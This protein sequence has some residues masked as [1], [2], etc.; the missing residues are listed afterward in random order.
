MPSRSSTWLWRAPFLGLASVLMAACSQSSPPSSTTGTPPGP[1]PETAKPIS[2]GRSL[3]IAPTG[4]APEDVTLTQVVDP[5]SEAQYAHSLPPPLLGSNF[6]GL[7]FDVQNTGL[8]AVTFDLGKYLVLADNSG[9]RYS[10][11]YAV[12][13]DCPPFGGSATA[14]AEIQPGATA[15]GCVAFE[16]TTKNKLT[17]VILGTSTKTSGEWSISVSSSTTSTTAPS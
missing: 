2:L 8:S 13:S 9:S 10:L 4:G 16:V 3:T 17:Q 14:I 1:P 12:L 6:V 11:S 15:T 5:A 7:M